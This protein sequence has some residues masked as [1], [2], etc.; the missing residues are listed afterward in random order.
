MSKEKGS[1]SAN[2]A[3]L[4]PMLGGDE[5]NQVGQLGNRKK[6]PR[7]AVIVCFVFLTAM[8][9]WP[10]AKLFLFT[11]QSE[12]DVNG[13]DFQLPFNWTEVSGFF[14][15]EEAAFRHTCPG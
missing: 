11:G 13:A 2:E 15:F 14:G 3:E 6:Q 4:Q 12:S 8:N 7:I 1:F 5:V 10:V 9:L